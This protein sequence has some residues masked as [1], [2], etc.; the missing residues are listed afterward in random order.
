MKSVKCSVRIVLAVFFICGL[1][2]GA[3]AKDTLIVAQMGDALTLDP[4]AHNGIV[5]ASMCSN[6]YDTLIM[7]DKN[8]D[9][10]PGL[11]VKWENPDNLTWIFHLREGVKFHNG[12]PFTARD[13]KYSIERI[14]N[15]KPF[16]TMIGVAAYIQPISGV[17]IIDE[18]TIELKTEKPFGALL[19]NLRIPYIMN[20]EHTEKIEKEKGIESVSMNPMGTGAF[21]FVEWV[22]GDHLTL[23]RNEAWW[24]GK[25]GIPNVV[26]RQISNDA[27][28][29]AAL[30]SGEVDI[31]AE[32][33]VRDVARVKSNPATKVVV[34][35]GMRTV[36]FI[37]DMGRDKTPGI[38]TSPPNPLKN[39]LVRQAI[40]QAIDEDAIVKVVMNGF[41]RP[42]TQFCS[43]SHFGWN[44]TIKRLPYDPETAKKL[45]AEAGYPNGFPL[46]IDS[47]NNRYVNDEQI[48][49]AVAQMLN[50]V[51]IKATCRARPKHIVFKEFYDP[52][53]AC[54]SMWI[55]SHV[56]PTADVSAQFEQIWHTKV[57]GTGY[58]AYNDVG[59]G[60]PRYSNPA[61]DL[62]I[63]AAAGTTDQNDRQAY[64]QAAALVGVNDVPLVPL[65]YQN[66]IYGM[67]NKVDWI[68]RPDYYLT[69]WDAKFME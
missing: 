37:F 24:G 27:T 21:K 15:W 52:K 31:A 16:G 11:A 30:L 3:P 2:G 65:H 13:V 29:T 61:F 53:I 36:N 34:L 19:R 63:D 17:R 67:S 25:V 41:A 62:L 49:M 45:L 22:Q 59:D 43:D 32:L 9:V 1:A 58:G 66:D 28:R 42:S 44:P 46:R 20:Q 33:A 68:P 14:L 8:M 12:T 38:A 26:F 47:S 54:C 50:K 39:R 35:D 60:I 48:C 57:S 64:L 69:V 7:L 51:G 55:F 4:H 23:E 10:Q 5:E 6:I 40:Y 18:Y 56:V